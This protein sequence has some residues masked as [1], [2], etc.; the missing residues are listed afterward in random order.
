MDKITLKY[1]RNLLKEHWK[2]VPISFGDNVEMTP[3]ILKVVLKTASSGSRFRVYFDD[4]DDPTWDL[5]GPSVD[6]GT[7]WWERRFD[8]EAGRDALNKILRSHFG[9]STRKVEL[10]PEAHLAKCVLEG[11]CCPA[12][13]LDNLEINEERFRNSTLTVSR[14]CGNCNSEWEEFYALKGY[15]NLKTD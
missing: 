4:G 2:D 7:I 8:A 9:P 1:C 14:S 10:T 5:D 3:E 6:Y 12:C 15:K 13:G 11:N